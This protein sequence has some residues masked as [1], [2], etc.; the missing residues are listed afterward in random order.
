[1]ED[2]W[3]ATLDEFGAQRG[4]VR[5]SHVVVDFGD[6]SAESERLLRGELSGID[7]SHCGL[8]TVRGKDARSFLHRLCTQDLRDAAPGTI[9]PAIFVN[10]KGRIEFDTVAIVRDEEVLLWNRGGD[11]TALIALLDRYHF[12]EDVAFEDRSK[13]VAAI[14]VFGHDAGAAIDAAIQATVETGSDSEA[15]LRLDPLAGADDATRVILP[16]DRAAAVWRALV[17]AGVHPAGIAA[18]DRLRIERRWPA[19]GAELEEHSNPLEAGRRDAIS[20]RKGCYVGQEVIARLD[21]YDKV[22]R[23]LASVV[24]ATPGE[25]ASKCEPRAGDRLFYDGRDVGVLTTVALDESERARAL[26]FLKTSADDSSALDVVR[27]GTSIGRAEVI[28]AS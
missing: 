5:G 25:G 19:A 17:G 3:T 21:T 9:L 10:G 6:R 11:P 14:A 27:D 15:A 26:A 24:I 4:T 1:M 22:S 8:V 16:R 7:E 20:F 18:W 13:H 2:P 23:R 12:S 28:D